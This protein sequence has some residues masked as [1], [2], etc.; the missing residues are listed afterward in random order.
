MPA[1]LHPIETDLKQLTWRAAVALAGRCA[2]RVQPILAPR[3][4]LLEASQKAIA[5]AEEFARG[6]DREPQV[7]SAI[8]GT[9]RLFGR[10]PER[11]LFPRDPRQDLEHAMGASRLLGEAAENAF[12]A[13]A[14]PTKPSCR[15]ALFR[16]AAEAIQQSALVTAITIEWVPISD[17]FRRD[18][19]ARYPRQA[20]ETAWAAE[21]I[22]KDFETLRQLHP[23]TGAEVGRLLD[24]SEGGDVG[25]LWPAGTPRWF[26]EL[27]PAVLPARLPFVIPVEANQTPQAVRQAIDGSTNP[28]DVLCLSVGE[29]TN[30][31]PSTPAALDWVKGFRSLPSPGSAL[32]LV[33]L[34]SASP[35]VSAEDEQ[36]ARF[37][38]VYE[39]GAVVFSRG[40]EAGEFPDWIRVQA[41]LP[42][43]LAVRVA[44]GP[45]SPSGA[46]LGLPPATARG[47]GRQPAHV[48]DYDPAQFE[49]AVKRLNQAEWWELDY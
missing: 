27:R 17:D 5:L 29:E 44:A 36:K 37:A 16:H 22:R 11:Q 39:L 26:E 45:S 46:T 2:R 8:A 21:A 35:A 48:D 32:S 34:A 43:V 25:P 13:L 41:G 24:P 10:S 12:W 18:Y 6:T 30:A 20:Q 47:Y 4:N 49:R 3:G 38:L 33:I 40:Y 28:A 23:G 42:T 19:E 14:K 7:T 9:A 1:E 31:F 15:D